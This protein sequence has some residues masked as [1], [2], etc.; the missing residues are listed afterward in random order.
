MH[1][2]N[3]AYE[4]AMRWANWELARQGWVD[5]K[6]ELRNYLFATDTTQTTN[7]KLPWRNKTTVPKLTQIRDNLHANYISALMPNDDWVK[8][9]AGDLK[10]A[11]KEKASAIEAYLGTKIRTS[12]FRTEVSKLLYDYIDYGNAFA[13]IDYVHKDRDTSDGFSP[14][15]TGPVLTRISPLDIVF[16]PTAASFEDSPKI[17]RQLITLA[18]LLVMAEEQPENHDRFMEVFKKTTEARASLQKLISDGEHVKDDAYHKDGFGPMIEYMQTDVVELLTFSGDIYYGEKLH[19]H[20]KITVIDRAFVLEDVPLQTWGR[21]D[22]Y[23]HAGWRKR[24]D[25]LYAMGPLDNLVGMQYRIDHLEN[26]KAD[27]YDLTAMPPLKIKGDVEEFT[28]GPLE[29][30][31]MGEDGDVEALKIDGTALQADSQIQYLQQQMEEFAGAPKQAMGI[32]TPGEKTAFEVQ[33]LE[34]AAG[35]I[36]QE[37]ITSFEIELMEPALN[38]ML[39]SGRRNIQGIEEISMLDADLGLQEFME[40]SPRDITAAGVL[41]PIGARHFAAKAQLVQT[42][43]AFYAAGVGQDPAVSTHMS[44]KRLAKLM[45]EALNLKKFE[46]VSDNIRVMEMAETMRLQNM[47]QEQMAMEAQQPALQAGMAEG[48]VPPEGEDG[49]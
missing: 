13:R 19:R 30:V 14:M 47:L 22:N 35:R 17:E 32:R 2:D 29:E 11:T 25:N 4:I 23:V 6:K 34:N 12:N 3:L 7:S 36:F 28:W 42:L 46:L 48:P 8:W 33:T 20:R 16:N 45:E 9:E 38:L 1:P 10:D 43:Q 41:R 18:D 44:G 27:M 39:E 31:F 40:I 21:K 26:T 5:E 37:K 24:P 49:A 15:Y